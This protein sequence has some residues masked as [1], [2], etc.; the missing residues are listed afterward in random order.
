MLVFTAENI[1]PIQTVSICAS[2]SEVQK[3]LQRHKDRYLFVREDDEIVGFVKTRNIKGYEDFSSLLEEMTPLN[4]VYSITCGQQVPDVYKLLGEDIILVRDENQVLCGYLQRDDII[5]ELLR[6]DETIDLFRTILSSIPLGIFVVDRKGYIINYNAEGLRMVKMDA[7]QIQNVKA[8]EIFGAEHIDRVLSTGE[9]VLNQLHI[10][11][12]MGILADYSPILNKENEVKGMIIIVQDL[13]MLEELAME[14]DYVK[15]LNKD[16][17]AI[18]STVYDEILVVDNEGRLL[19][20]SDNKMSDFWAGDMNELIGK[21]L[22]EFEEKGLFKPSVTRLVLE[23]K[24]KVS[25]IQETAQGRK[26]LAVG[27]PVFDEQGNLDRIV[28]ASRDITETTKLKSELKQV[29]R[30]SE[31]YKKELVD[32][33]KREM[34]NRNIIYCSPKI[35]RIM[36]DIEKVAR[37]SSTVLLTGESGVG[38]EV[39]AKAIHQLGP[40]SSKPFLKINCG[41][42]PENLLE[43][44]LFGYEKGAFTG[45]DPKGKIGYFRQADKGVLFL[46]EIAEMPLSLQ[47][48]L[49]RVLQEREVIPVGGIQPIPIDVQIV[50]ATNKNLE[51]LV[52]KGLFREDLYYRLNVIPIHIPPLRERPEDIPPLAYYF[53]QKLNETHNTNIQLAPDALNL[54]E[55]YPWPGNV[56]ELQNVIERAVVTVDDDIIVADQ[57]YRLLQWEKLNTKSKPIITNIMPLPEALEVVEEQLILLAMEKYK[58]TTMAAKMLGI[59]QSSVS[60]K[61]QKIMQ[62]RAEKSKIV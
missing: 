9:T 19:R 57:I 54:L 62:K 58:T 4:R 7:E 60:R 31:Q 25:V 51:Q 24:K 13:P 3:H 37:F 22:V 18:L 16:L 56:R 27:T 26:V 14:L 15:G 36:K 45:A 50:A 52:E 34:L 61:Y 46:D 47:V 6:Q 43:S 23:R 12:R 35:E 48:K 55:V 29:R 20:F 39:F 53:L 2:I 8:S 11:P 41:A 59:S 40:R 30:L 21:N 38:K 1:R 44:E 17:N 28:I 5:I 32:L 33:K 10:T 49:L 42:I